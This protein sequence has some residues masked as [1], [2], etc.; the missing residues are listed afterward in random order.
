MKKKLMVSIAVILLGLVGVRLYFWRS[1]ATLQTFAL[2][3]LQAGHP[4]WRLERS[5]TNGVKVT[6]GSTVGHVY[7]NNIQREAGADRARARELLE[8]S[9]QEL[10]AL[11]QTPAPPPLDVVKS[12]LRP[13]LVPRDYAD[14]YELAAPEDLGNRA[15]AAAAARGSCAVARFASAEAR[16]QDTC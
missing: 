2:Q 14:Q 16:G 8:Q 9:A 12:R 7:S 1:M 3:V 4:D 5:G 10:S 13:V 11:F 6:S 15:R